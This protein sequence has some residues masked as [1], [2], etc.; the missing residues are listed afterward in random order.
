ME[1]SYVDEHIVFETVVGSRAY[2]TN[3]ED[4][5]YDKS[6]VMIPGIEYFFGFRSFEQY[7]D[8]DT[9][10][11][12]FD[13]RKAL[14]LISENNPNMMDLLF[15][16]DRCVV[17]MTPYWQK[18]VENAQIFVTK[19]CRYT[20]AR[21]AIAQLERIKT[22]RK[23]LLD[24]P[25]HMP[26]RENFGLSETPMFPTVQIKAICNLALDLIAEE[27]KPNLIKEID[28][29]YGDYVIP[30]FLKYV[31]EDQ[32]PLG[33]EWI[34]S[35]VKA[36]SRTVLSLGNSFIKDEYLEEARKELAFYH[37]KNDWD[38]FKSWEKSRN[39]KRAD[40]EVKFGYDAKHAMHLVRLLRM[41]V[42][43]LETKKVNVDR[44]Y[45]DA[46]E[47]KA[48]R[49]GAWSYERVEEYAHEIDAK[50]DTSY[51]NSDLP[52]T[53]DVEKI[54]GLCIDSVDSFLKNKDYLKS[55]GRC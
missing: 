53:V 45:I 29:V 5:D 15:M 36:Q 9:D 19:R 13:I 43:I 48:I 21:Y 10:R 2:G 44:T 52:K 47:L 34:Q 38:R 49:E 37:A 41:G 16:P 54:D 11:T 46:D 6:G 28:K 40:L 26:T 14:N 23:Y 18:I 42:E 51:A 31:K 1:K 7:T 32:R 55:A 22:H 4:S 12:I 20:F 50:L 17:K 27:E 35:G 25:K 33:M 3:Y 24:P 8:P 39:K 30:L